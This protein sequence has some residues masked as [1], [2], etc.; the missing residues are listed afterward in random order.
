MTPFQPVN[1]LDFD[2]EV[3]ASDLPVLVDFKTTWCGPCKALLPILRELSD[4]RA[5]R[6]KVVTV[7]ADESPAL[8]SRF[9]VR[10]FPTVIAFA[11][12][13]EVGR[14]LGLTRKEKLAALLPR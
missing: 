6:L 13:R 4:E 9:G 8:A 5:G 2:Q 12:G 7:D 14:Q 11:D 3:L 10:G 1:E